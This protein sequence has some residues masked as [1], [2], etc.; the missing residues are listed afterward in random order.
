MQLTWQ[1]EKRK[2]NDLIP[3]EQNPREMSE[4]QVKHLKASL[5]KFNLAEIPAINTDNVIL[6][7][8]QRLKILQILGRGD[9]EIDVRVPSRKLTEDEVKEYNIRSNANSGSFNFDILAN[10]FSIDELKGWGFPE[11][12]LNRGFGITKE[13]PPHDPN[14]CER[15]K[16]LKKAVQ[17]HK[18]HSGHEIKLEENESK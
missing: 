15:C 9:E 3:Y 12:D 17:G 1:T 2:V 5:E 13:V 10:A 18:N 14:E 6:A 11:D 8:H 16:E 4:E 7:G